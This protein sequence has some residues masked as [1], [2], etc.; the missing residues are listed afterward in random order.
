MPVAIIK[1]GMELC[2]VI[3]GIPVEMIPAFVVLS[4]NDSTT[5]FAESS[6][7]NHNFLDFLI[8]CLNVF[9]KPLGNLLK[10]WKKCSKTQI[11]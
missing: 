4:H 2:F 3:N 7:Q 10:T 11:S 9:G 8:F 5:V 1:G 6:W